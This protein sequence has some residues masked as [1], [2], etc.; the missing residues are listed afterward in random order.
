MP[1]AGRTALDLD[2]RPILVFWE[3]TKACGLSCR[4][5]RASAISQP[6]QGE[7]TTAEA[8]RFVESLAGFGMP[9]PVLVATGGDVLLRHDLDAQLGR[10]RALK[11]PVALAPSV[12]PLLTVERV[13]ELH[14]AGVKVA[15]ISLDGATA[16]THDG[17]RGVEGHFAETVEALRRLRQ[18]GLTVQVNTVVMRDTVDELPA[19]ARIVKESGASIWEVFFLV[20]VGRGRALGELTP[21]ENEDVCHFLVDASRYGFV[22]RTVEAPFFRRV[23]AWRKDEAGETQVGARYGLGPLY[24]QLAAALRSELGSPTSPPRAQTKGTRDGRGIVFVAHDGEIHP[25]GFLPLSLGNVK[26]DE[27]VRVY[28]EHPLLRRIRAAD[29]SGRCGSCPYREL[30]GG[31]RARAYASAG[32]PLAEDSACAYQPT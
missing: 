23:V 4:H 11:V 29:F 22:V 24:E 7:L 32:D 26:H 3:T 21:A 10:A 13:A 8:A 27:I 31:S 16:A 18:G 25:S 9:R 20:R 15:S 19:I 1:A 5:C 17:V 30:C 12:T 2:Q 28:R 14:G 6:L